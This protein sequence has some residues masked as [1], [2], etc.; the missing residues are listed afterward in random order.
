MSKVLFQKL[1]SL[2]GSGEL[3]SMVD[4][5]YSSLDLL[6][7]IGYSEKGQY[8][9]IVKEFIVANDIDFSHWRKGGNSLAHYLEKK[10]PVCCKIFFTNEKTDSTTCSR[11]CA[12]TFFRSGTNNPNYAGSPTNRISGHKYREVAYAQYGHICNRCGYSNK[13]AL[14][15]HHK[16]RDRTNNNTPNLEVL[17]S[18]CHSIE[19]KN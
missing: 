4:N 5:S 8:N 10:C 12:N 18:N 14:E 2:L 6:R 1:E 16:D 15:I 3:L 13:L 7:R 19:H 17:C 9:K 11:S